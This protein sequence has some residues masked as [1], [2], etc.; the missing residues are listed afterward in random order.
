M[1]PIS[2]HKIDQLGQVAKCAGILAE[3]FNVAFG[4]EWTQETAN[5]KLVDFFHSPHFMGWYVEQDQEIIGGC[6]GNIETYYSGKYYYLKEMF[7]TPKLQA[8]G[9]GQQ[10][11]K[12]IQAELKALGIKMIILYTTNEGHQLSFYQKQGFEEIP[13]MRMLLYSAED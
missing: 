6:I 7:M 1:D 13:G 5:E 3:S 8:K 9:I 12:N 10:L 4:E 11:L 2:I